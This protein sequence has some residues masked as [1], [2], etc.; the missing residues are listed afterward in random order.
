MQTH[1]AGYMLQLLLVAAC[2]GVVS[3]RGTTAVTPVA[4]VLD[5]L[6]ELLTKGQAEKKDEE[7]RYSAFQQWCSSTKSEKDRTIKA[8][9]DAITQLEADIAKATADADRLGQ[10][11]AELDASIN[12]WELNVKNS[13]AVRKK[14]HTDYSATHQDYSESIDAIARALQTLKARTADVPQSLIEVQRVA[15][16][17]LSSDARLAL[18]SFLQTQRGAQPKPNAYEFQSQDVIDMLEK[19]KIRFQDERLVAQKE[20]MNR[21]HAFELM[22]EKLANSIKHAEDARAEKAQMK[23]RMQEDAAEAKGDLAETS[24]AKGADEA[25]LRDAMSNC[26]QKANDYESRQKLRSQELEALQKAIDIIS[27]EQ[28]SGAAETHLPALSQLS[29]GASLA[30]L[31][32]TVHPASQ[33]QA[34]EYLLGQAKKVGSELLETMAGRLGEDPFTKVKQMIKDLLT[35]LMEEANSEADHKAWCDS[36]L[37]T[38]EKTR[39]QKSREASDLAA[40]VDEQGAL[41]A[42]LAQ[43]ISDLNAAV[44]ELG[45]LMAKATAARTEEKAKNSATVEEAKAAQAAVME[46]MKIL[47]EFYAGAASAT[48]LTQLSGRRQAPEEDAPFVFDGPYKGMQSEHGGIVGMLEVIQSDFARLEAETSSSEDEA[49]REFETL[50]ADSE[51]DTELKETEARHKGFAKDRA[52]RALNQAKKDLAATQAELDAAMAYYDKLKPSCLDSGADYEARVGRREE[53]IASLK[54]ALVILTGEDLSG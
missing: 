34:A 14:E 42:Q 6:S 44:V 45:D 29:R 38:N 9:S 10:E 24:A 15:A 41:S 20:E 22:M 2:C 8:A 4:K 48:A 27:S 39:E 13:T 16:S 43:E 3:G 21:K 54:E 33:D 46:A 30:Q 5:M 53:E 36:E 18:D 7:V 52:V 50:I 40:Q 23:A 47:K 12:G 19:L 49:Q 32:S 28:V 37:A 51:K 1:R 35:K 11:I 26:E 25:Y 31:R 17:H